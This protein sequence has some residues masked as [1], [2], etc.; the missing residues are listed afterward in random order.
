[1]ITGM[2]RSFS[3]RMLSVGVEPSSSRSSRIARSGTGRPSTAPS[4]GTGRPS[5]VCRLGTHCT[6]HGRPA[7]V[8]WY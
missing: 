1:M 5:A 4:S 3:S 6:V 7:C 8:N 2:E